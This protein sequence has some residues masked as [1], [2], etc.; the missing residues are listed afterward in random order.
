MNKAPVKKDG[1]GAGDINI[2][3]REMIEVV[4]TL[5][6]VY[7]AET[8]ILKSTNGRAFLEFQGIKSEAARAYQSAISA[9]ILRKEEIKASGDPALREELKAMQ[10]RFSQVVQINMEH[11][12]RMRKCTER[13]GQTMRN[14]AIRAA[15]EK[16]TYSY[17]ENGRLNNSTN[18]RIVSTGISETA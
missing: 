12:G 16:S 4:R 2:S 1:K 3:I 9:L 13:L 10:G 14:A 11:L 15:Q 17:G 8:E 5:Q 7:E 6:A 18:N